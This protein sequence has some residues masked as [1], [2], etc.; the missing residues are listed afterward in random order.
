MDAT[1]PSVPMS[2]NAA[3]MDAESVRKKERKGNVCDNIHFA[4]ETK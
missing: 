4:T 3:R 2:E 1:E